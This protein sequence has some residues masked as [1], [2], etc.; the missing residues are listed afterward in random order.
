[1]MAYVRSRSVAWRSSVPRVAGLAAIAAGVAISCSS[2]PETPGDATTGGGGNPAGTGANTGGDGGAATTSTTTGTAGGGGVGAEGGAGGSGGGGACVAG[3]IVC[4]GAIKKVC[5]GNG[6]FTD[7]ED[8]A[9]TGLVCAPNLGCVACVPG[10][11]TCNGDVGSSCKPDGSGTVDETCN[12]DQGTTCNPVTGKC[13]GAC[14]VTQLGTSYIGCD[15]YPTVTANLVE[16]QFSFAVAVSNTTATAATVTASMGAAIVSTVTVAPN[17]VQVIALPWQTTLKGPDVQPPFY[18]IEDFPA[19]VKVTDGAYRLQST[20]PVTVYQFN[21]LP[22][23]VNGSFSYSNDASLLLPVNVWTGTYRVASRHNFYVSRGFYAVTASEDGTTVTVTAGPTTGPVKSGVPGLG[24]DGNGTVTL[25][26]GDVFE[27]VTNGDP[28]LAESAS[29]LTGTLI[30]ADKPVQVIGG[31][32]CIYIPSGTAACDHLEESIFPYETLS[33]EYLV[34][35]PLIP[36]GGQNAKVEVVRVVA[37][38][39]N[40]TLTYDPPQAGAPAAIGE[41]GGWVEIQNTNASFS[42][43]SNE[44]V[45]VVQYMEGQDAGGNSGDPA[46]ALAVAKDQYRDSYLFHAPTNYEYSYVNVIAP[47]GEQVLLDGG[48][49]MNFTPIGTTG[50][51]V[52]RTGVSNAGDGNHVITSA[53]PFGISVY[54]YGQYTSYWYPGGSDLEELHR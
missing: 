7:E 47:T 11:G 51:S 38:Q 44:P 26:A 13:D 35:A 40:T 42:I 29:D 45:L 9:L 21:P 23:T 5:D 30:S 32:Q 6:G 36:N 28:N 34:A 22:Y 43:V 4:D 14:S 17:S 8:C 19:S 15:Y 48:A 24:A 3:T 18:S 37:T 16:Q 39:P 31:H 33:T 53:M 49:V 52:A 1:M 27:V 46:M 20:Q 12:E 50:Y 2:D 10:T 25:D 41:A 54:G